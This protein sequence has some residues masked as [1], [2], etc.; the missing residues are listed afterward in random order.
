MYTAK[1]TRYDMWPGSY[2][3]WGSKKYLVASIDQSLRRMGLDYVD[4]LK[5]VHA[6]NR[7]VNERGQSLAQI[8]DNVGILEHVRFS[9]EERERIEEILK[10]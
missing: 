5:K 4:T 3:N 2:G 6:L 10:E 9:Q 8:V 1:E 7:L